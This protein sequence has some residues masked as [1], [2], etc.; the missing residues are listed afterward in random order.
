MRRRSIIPLIE[1]AVLIA[2]SSC[3]TTSSQPDAGT[4]DAGAL[5]ASTDTTLADAGV[6]VIDAADEFDDDAPFINP[7]PIPDGCSVW[8]KPDAF[9]PCGY[10]EHINSADLC[11]VQGDADIQPFNVCFTLCDPTEPD[12]IYYNFGTDDAGDA[13]IIITC[14]AGCVGRLH[15]S[16]RD[17]CEPI[18]SGSIGD[19]LARA[20]AL[21]A[22]SID[23]FHIVA[24]DLAR[25]GAPSSLRRDAESAALDEE[26]HARIVGALAAEF[27]ARAATP[28][29]PCERAHDMLG[30][31][32]ENAVEGC[33]RET[34]GAALAMWQSANAKDARV[35]NAMRE[36]AADEARHADLGWRI[37]AWLASS[38]HAS[39]RRATIQARE[40]A[41]R[42]LE[43]SIEAGANTF[44]DA[45]G[46]PDRDASRA[47]V[48][49]LRAT[50]WSPPS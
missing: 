10:G 13:D 19:F 38:Q 3:G 44:D 50:V 21:E 33:V 20:A 1:R 22:A 29:A 24:A 32:I 42:D 43:R 27:G 12:C 47:I 17:C 6:D 18:G 9:A 11:G 37:D 34:Y 8:G 39:A 41:I 45:L 14:G 46:L 5:D 49:A 25:F 15:E 2:A 30:F 4:A 36:I 40:A 31:A 28:P 16:A 7:Y 23:S 35:R 48:A 26:R